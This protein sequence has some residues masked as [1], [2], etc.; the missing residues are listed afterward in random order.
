M[1]KSVLI[2]LYLQYLF[3][4]VS[5]GAGTVNRCTPSQKNGKTTK[6]ES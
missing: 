4:I 1:T 3:A 5:K 6:T 2:L